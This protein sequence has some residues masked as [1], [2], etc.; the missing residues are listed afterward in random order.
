MSNKR[1]RT[2]GAVVE[3]VEP[4]ET[5]EQVEPTPPVDESVPPVDETP[6][7]EPTPP[8]DEIAVSV[9]DAQDET[10][11]PAE[12]EEPVVEAVEP[13]E[14]E[15]VEQ[16]LPSEEP[17]VDN[18]PQTTPVSVK[19]AVAD[20][21]N[22]TNPVELDKHRF[23][24]SNLTL[25][26]GIASAV[27]HLRVLGTKA[28]DGANA[29]LTN[30]GR[31]QL[32]RLVDAAT[33]R[34]PLDTTYWTHAHLV[35]YLTKDKAPEVLHHGTMIDDTRLVAGLGVEELNGYSTNFI[36]DYWLTH[37]DANSRTV[38]IRR[39]ASGNKAVVLHDAP[40]AVFAK[41]VKAGVEPDYIPGKPVTVVKSLRRQ[42]V[43]K[44]SDWYAREL[45]AY[46]QGLIANDSKV[47]DADLQSYAASVLVGDAGVHW[48]DMVNY[49]RNDVAIPRTSLGCLVQDSVREATPAIAWTPEEL[50]CV[51]TG[52]ITT[53][54]PE[55]E[56]I[57]AMKEV[58]SM[59]TVSD[60]KVYEEVAKVEKAVV[61][62]NMTL[63]DDALNAFVDVMSGS[64]SEQTAG[65]AHDNLNRM[66]RKLINMDFVDFAKGYGQLV[67][68][69][70]KLRGGV[71]SERKLFFGLSQVSLN[72]TAAIVHEQLLFLIMSTASAESRKAVWDN[73][74]QNY[75]FDN[76]SNSKAQENLSQ[77]YEMI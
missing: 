42:S 43:D 15:V 65:Q 51:A 75:L 1:K 53:K 26:R 59:S 41:W 32:K 54:R 12:Q 47:P 55:V 7:P 73:Y 48:D 45:L 24:V 77:Y 17:V 61:S 37:K 25:G 64:V 66:L 71:F 18:N 31:E 58:F 57:N 10:P 70:A 23:E 27:E 72:S 9:D 44:A 40:E 49:I 2:M 68:A 8:V 39:L 13:V 21:D 19:A 6:V 20:L 36:K 38:L 56:L 22:I 33:M 5:I 35:E 29:V 52:E 28:Q 74:N 4:T 50:V 3:P 14:P 69:A 63:V 67:R 30:T 60:S 62:P 76:L 46:V 34:I 16:E 11:D